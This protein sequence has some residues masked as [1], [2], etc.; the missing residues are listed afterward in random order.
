MS[1]ARKISRSRFTACNGPCS[2]PTRRGRR[3]PCASSKTLPEAGS[4]CASAASTEAPASRRSVARL[5]QR[6][7]LQL[8]AGIQVADGDR[9]RPGQQDVLLGHQG[10]RGI[11]TEKPVSEPLRVLEA[12]A[13]VAEV[14]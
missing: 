4:T 8:V 9:H 10:G 14:A 11:L 12:D 5:L 2:K 7:E 6:G 3:P 1:A 13:A